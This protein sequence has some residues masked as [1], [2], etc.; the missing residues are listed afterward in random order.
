MIRMSALVGVI[1]IGVLGAACSAAPAGETPGET[2]AAVESHVKDI[3]IDFCNWDH[4]P[5]NSVCHKRLLAIPGGPIIPPDTPC[6][7][8]SNGKPAIP[9]GDG[10]Y[11]FAVEPNPKCNGAPLVYSDGNE[12]F[13]SHATCYYLPDGTYGQ[14]GSVNFWTAPN[15]A[16]FH[17]YGTMTNPT[18]ATVRVDVDYSIDSTQ[19][20]VV[21][22][23]VVI[24]LQTQ[25]AQQQ[26]VDYQATNS[27]WRQSGLSELQVTLQPNT[28]FRVEMR[29]G[30]N[31]GNRSVLVKSAHVFVPECVIDFNTGQCS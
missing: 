27:G 13:G 24:A 28:S 11:I 8:D 18:P 14:A 5:R 12:L 20:A 30:H 15:Q 21:G 26:W 23:E 29:T 10:A 19:G 6:E 3:T 2:E 17:M 7:F 31:N 9:K 1:G 25:N 22:G 16:I 4:H